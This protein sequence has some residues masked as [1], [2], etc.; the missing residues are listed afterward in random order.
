LGRRGVAALLIAGY[1]VAGLL[2]LVVAS[3]TTRITEVPLSAQFG[4]FQTLPPTYWLGMAM[5][6]FAVILALRSRSEVL[7]MVT[8]VLLLAALAGTPSLFEPNPRYWD[9]YLHL[10][11]GQTIQSTGHL[12]SQNIGQYVANWPGTFLVDAVLLEVTAMPP[13][14]LLGVYPFVS[15]GLTFLVLFTYLRSKFPISISGASAVLSA[16]FGVWAQFHLSPQ[17]LGFLLMLL[18]LSVVWRRETRWRA[19][20]ALLFV[21]LV[22]SHPTS[23]L[24]LLSILVLVPITALPWARKS[25][26]VREDARFE[27]RVAV[28]YALTWLAWLYFRATASSSAAETAI[29]NRIGALI[30]LPE[31][32]LNLATARAV[33]NLF[34]WGSRLRLVSLAVYGLLGIP[35]LIILARR[36]SSRF[37]VRFLLAGLL[38]PAIIGGADILGFGGQ[39]YDRSLLF[40]STLAPAMCLTVLQGVRI[41]LPKLAFPIAAAVIVA[42]SLA[43]AS[44]AYYQ[45]AFNYVSG[46][47]VAMSQFLE[48]TSPQA[49][50]LDGAFPV[51]V[52]IDS[53]SRTPHVLLAYSQTYPTALQNMTGNSTYAVFDPTAKLWYRQWKG[54]NIYTFYDAERAS[55][56]LIYS[57]GKGVICITGR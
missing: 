37:P 34:P 42:A 48:R 11:E 50:V 18:I 13:M 27:R 15:G 12:P 4:L 5:I 28:T 54:I 39:F 14:L 10:S 24:I 7:I 1:S 33:E 29:V 40:F 23:T 9:A 55:L 35:A 20:S 17:S 53:Q 8:G 56:S 26:Q 25:L 57:N 31:Y 44:T 46:E 16:L 49:I 3:L 45:E 51:P 36:E 21:G 52:W 19:L 47:S 6:G 30:S 38:G 22:V 2:F 43:S 41:R 32:T